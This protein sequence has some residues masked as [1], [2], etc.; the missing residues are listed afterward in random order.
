MILHICGLRGG[1]E[2]K[3]EKA[4]YWKLQRWKIESAAATKL[5]S[6][7]VLCKY[8]NDHDVVDL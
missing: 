5:E 4:D 6:T 1:I 7:Q 2:Q 8:F 3:I